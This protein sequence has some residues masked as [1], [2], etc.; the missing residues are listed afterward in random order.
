[1]KYIVTFQPSG[2]RCVGSE[3]ET[4]MDI[5]RRNGIDIVASCGGSETCGKC[6][7]RVEPAGL[8]P[9]RLEDRK[10]MNG[11]TSAERKFLT[12]FEL[13][14]SYRLACAVKVN[15]DVN[16]FVPKQ[17]ANGNQVILEDGRSCEAK[18]NPNL[19]VYALTLTKP[20]LEDYRD[21]FKRLTDA[22]H[23]AY[24]FLNRAVQIDY[25]VLKTLP[26]T[27][28]KA[29]WQ[30]SVA[31]IANQEIIAVRAGE[32][33]HF[34]GIA[35]DVGT[36]T[37]AAALCD[38]STGKVLKRK[39]RMNSQ[40][41]YGDDVI[42]RI[43]YTMQ[44]A[45]GLKLLHHAIIED[46]NEL[47]N[48]LIND[49]DIAREDIFEMVLV[50]NTV[51]EHI[52]LEIEPQYIGKVPFAAAVRQPLDIKARDLG[53]EIARSGNIHVLPVEAG[54]VGADNV[55]ALISQT[56]YRNKEMTLVVDIGTN[57][58][59]DFGND[60]KMYSTSCATGPAL[61][62]AQLSFGMRA[63][64]GAIEKV[65][66]NPETL[67][68]TYQTIGSMKG[69]KVKAKGICGSG[70]I[71]VV[72]EMAKTGIIK[73]TGNFNKNLENSL[74]RKN[75]KGQWE[76][77][78]A[79]AADTE[80]GMDI[81]VSQKDIRAV[82][83]AKAALY[84]GAKLLMQKCGVEKLEKVILAGAF[85]SYIDK[86]NALYI[87]LL[88]PCEL[89]AIEVVGNAAGEGARLA[90]LDIDK[91]GEAKW[92]AENIEFVE[93]ATDGEFQ[94]EFMNGMSFDDKS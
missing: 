14:R 27:L 77:V 2:R 89:S 21:D 63:A 18:I 36:T 84:A 51:M 70:I 87:G 93:A 6:K 61:E 62:G 88:P 82:Q 8:K 86:A 52:L 32:M 23:Q 19:K 48:E 79:L 90:L 17:S 41:R 47:I 83:L 11:L 5:A 56:P 40:V 37:L 94:E 53:I 54:F 69:K 76:Y 78:V 68:A 65:K 45:D 29:N 73:S 28:R 4:I 92:I 44:Q 12:Q 30:V 38:L 25:E 1:M 60:E 80:S 58:E 13:L 75:E 39:S 34:Y 71:D 67:V 9:W 26:R 66:I 31:V 64:E 42:S 20:T 50:G 22:L 46:I 85:G 49:S 74:V 3:K 81:T 33:E 91:R 57:G 59:I 15:T 43:S 24:P 7:V 35:V 55:A 16:V 10:Y 72:A